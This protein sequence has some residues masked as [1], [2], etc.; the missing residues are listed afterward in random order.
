MVKARKKERLHV[1]LPQDLLRALEVR[2][3]IEGKH[4]SEVLEEAVR[5]WLSDRDTQDLE[6]R[7]GIKARF[8]DIEELILSLRAWIRDLEIKNLYA[9]ERTYALFEGQFQER[10]QSSRE[11]TN[12]VAHERIARMSWTDGEE[13]A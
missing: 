5:F 4:R 11:E 2:R 9:T 6:R 12:R 1:T 7:I 3:E 10:L 8:G 13:E